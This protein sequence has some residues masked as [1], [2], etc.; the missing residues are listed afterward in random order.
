MAF[1]FSS[2]RVLLGNEALMRERLVEHFPG[3]GYKQASMLLRDLG[4]AENLAIIDTHVVKFSGI[5][6][7]MP[8]YKGTSQSY[9]KC[10]AALQQF[11]SAYGISVASLDRAIWA[12]MAA[13]HRGS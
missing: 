9:L 4:L 6:I 10:E 7:E 11:A 13:I 2:I 1:S 8:M 12:S 5:F 3:L